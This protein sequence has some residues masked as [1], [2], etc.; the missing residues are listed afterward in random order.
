V[1]GLDSGTGPARV[2]ADHDVAAQTEQAT[3]VVRAAT[4][5][6]WLQFAVPA[7]GVGVG[8]LTAWGLWRRVAEY[9]Y[10]P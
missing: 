3:A 1:A 7:A 9:R 8:A 6:G 2:P 10:Q 5:A 4:D